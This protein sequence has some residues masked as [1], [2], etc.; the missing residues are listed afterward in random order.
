[1]SR[2]ELLN[3]EGLRVDGRRANELRKITCRPGVLCQADGSAYI[4]H[5][6]TKV[7]AAIY[8]P[9]EARHR[10]AILHDRAIFNVEF[11]IAPFSTSER[12][13][14]SKNDKRS[15]E[16]AALVKQ[17]FEPVVM[18]TLFPRSQIDI[19]LQIL[20]HDG[21][22]LQACINA[23]TVALIDAGIPMIDYVCACTGGC[24]EKQ[25]VLDLNHIEESSESPELTI[26]VLPRSGKVTLVQMESRLHMES[27]E[28]VM[29]LA[30]EG[31]Q[32]I[33]S[34]IDDIARANTRQLL[35]K[36]SQ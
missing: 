2:L 34:T 11:N 9:R 30:I 15:L 10:G 29:N 14:R 24:L 25:P 33:H 17:T 26:G 8:G 20:Q 1:M 18:T 4:E 36:M 13:K 16:I 32:Q 3:P 21:G 12:K 23:A 19:Y 27:F 7:L 31:C 28:S 35:K 6:N 22:T 5:G